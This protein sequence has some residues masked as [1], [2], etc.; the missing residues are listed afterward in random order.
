M[1]Y[2]CNSCKKEF[3]I[4][5][6]RGTITLTNQYTPTPITIVLRKEICPYCH[7]LDFH[8]IKEAET[9]EEISEIESQ[10]VAKQRFLTLRRV[11]SAYKEGQYTDENVLYFFAGF[12]DYIPKE[13]DLKLHESEAES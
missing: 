7:Q 2:R 4:P 12:C 1:K 6:E 8:K 10:E 3:E 13:E 9:A 11:L 5:G